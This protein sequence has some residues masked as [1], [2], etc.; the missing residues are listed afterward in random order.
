M[1][2]L[3]GIVT[4]FVCIFL[5]I[6]LGY[7]LSNHVLLNKKFDIS[8]SIQ[9]TSSSVPEVPGDTIKTYN[10]KYIR[11]NYPS[12]LEIQDALTPDNGDN[13]M[14]TRSDLYAQAFPIVDAQKSHISCTGNKTGTKI[15]DN[16]IWTKYEE[17]DSTQIC[18]SLVNKGIQYIIRYYEDDTEITPITPVVFSSFKIK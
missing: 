13:V 9:P 3:F 12:T 15:V 1:K 14:F 8:T 18:I 6:F 5:L 4:F 7:Y 2:I 16:K 10:G 17:A 11:F